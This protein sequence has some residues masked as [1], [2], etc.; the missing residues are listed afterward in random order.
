MD[1]KYYLCLN[2]GKFTK[3][4]SVHR[5]LKCNYCGHILF[6]NCQ[7]VWRMYNVEVFTNT[8]Q[9]SINDANKELDDGLCVSCNNRFWCWTNL[10][11]EV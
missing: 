1:A 7:E 3:T 2:C 6:Y 8:A 10:I 5:V 11:Q 9:K 4:P